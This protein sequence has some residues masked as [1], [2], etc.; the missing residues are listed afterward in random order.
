MAIGLGVC[1]CVTGTIVSGADDQKTQIQG[2]IEGRIKKVDAETMTLTITTAQGRDRTFTITQETTMLGPRGGKVRRR[3]RD[4]R[5]H[6]G[7]AVTVVADGNKATE[8]HLGYDREESGQTAEHAKTTKPRTTGKSDAVESPTKVTGKTPPST[9]TQPERVPGKRYG[10][11]LEK[12]K[13]K[14][15]AA[16]QAEDEDNEVPGKVKRFDSTQHLLVITLVNGKDRSFLLSK[17]VK[18]LV[19]GAE[20]RRGLEDPALKAGASIEV[21]TD[22]GG[23][24]VKELKIVPASEIKRKRAG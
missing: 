10:A 12:A 1:I 20:S 13:A 19:R 6:E 23:H 16:A 3:L 24:K 17:D 2:G 18:V 7:L 8:L 22:E 4:P 11:A 21:F 14:S 9:D 5:F 15:A